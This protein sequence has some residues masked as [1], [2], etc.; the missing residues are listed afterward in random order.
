[1]TMYGVSC[2]HHVEVKSGKLLRDCGNNW[3]ISLNIIIKLK[4]GNSKQLQVSWYSK[5]LLFRQM[6]NEKL[7]ALLGFCDVRRAVWVHNSLKVWPPP[8]C[9]TF[10]DLPIRLKC[11]RIR[12]QFARQFPFQSFNF[13][14]PRLQTASREFA[15]RVSNLQ[16]KNVGVLVL[17]NQ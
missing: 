9:H 11:R 1:M 15:K 7:L 4:Q 2:G 5:V 6:N 13:I 12:P 14:L 10:A 3:T 16:K 17:L 8:D